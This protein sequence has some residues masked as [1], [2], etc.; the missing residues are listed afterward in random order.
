MM[1]PF[2]SLI[3]RR[4]MS[5]TSRRSVGEASRK[6]LT[7]ADQGGDARL[8]ALAT[9]DHP[10]LAHRLRWQQATAA[11]GGEGLPLRGGERQREGGA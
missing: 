8:A 2:F 10:Q 3:S 5:M 1:T 9:G 4:P 11:D 7:N 6:P